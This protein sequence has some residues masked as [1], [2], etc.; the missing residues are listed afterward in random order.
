[1]VLAAY[2]GVMGGFG[3]M[4]VFTF[5]SFLKPLTA[6]FGWS[7]EAVSGAFGIGALS[8]AVCSPFLGRLLDRFPP[9]RIIVPCASIFGLGFASLSLLTPHLWH[10]YA[11]F[12]LLG[13]VGNG[14]S[15]MGYSKAVASWF[16]RSRGKALAFVMAGSATGAAL[17]PPVAQGL[18]DR[19][20]WRAAYA[21]LGATALLLSIPL[22]SWLVREKPAVARAAEPAEGR[23]A[24]EAIR[25]STFWVLISTLF[26]GSISI[27]GAL[28]HLS[29]LLTDRGL[30]AATAALAASALGIS[31]FVG[32]FV[33]GALL[34]RFFGARVGCTIMI[35][36]ALGVLLL[37]RA[38]SVPSAVAAAILIGLGMGAEADITPYLLTRYFGLRWFAM[39][40]G[41][42]WTAYA[43]AGATGPWLMG[44]AFDLTKSYSAL[45]ELL[46]A[47]MAATSLAFLALP[48]YRFGAQAQVRPGNLLDIEAART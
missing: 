35:A 14:T 11:T 10:L 47:V 22:S 36:S 40:Y 29:P 39:L 41:W 32:R 17:F 25:T 9:R 2:F 16:D 27:N 19:Y 4:L 30:A 5:G 48:R 13:V 7:R 45:L 26:F 31:S 15:Q 3:S 12:A 28:T 46:A 24:R 6:T 23:T 20:G 42:S 1:M 44:R 18:I 37:A 8:V 34:D 33:T 43:I 21:T 38:A